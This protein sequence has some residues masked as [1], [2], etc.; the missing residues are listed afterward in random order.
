MSFSQEL[1]QGDIDPCAVFVTLE[2]NFSHES[3]LKPGT[4]FTFMYEGFAEILWKRKN[5]DITSKIPSLK[6]LKG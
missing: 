4:A 6:A 3:M 1:E 2:K 5:A